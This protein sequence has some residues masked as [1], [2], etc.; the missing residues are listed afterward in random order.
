MR[1]VVATRFDDADP[2]RAAAVVEWPEPINDDYWV[3]IDVKAASLN[4]HDLWTLRGVGVDASQ[5]PVPLG[6]DVAGI[7]PDGN[8]VVVY[9]VV[10][11]ASRGGGNEMHD[12]KR[13]MLPDLGHGTFADRV[14]VPRNCLVAKPDSLSFEEA[15]CLPTSW[16]TAYRMLFT[17]AKVKSG[18]L[19]LIQG[20]GGGVSTALTVL[21]ASQGVRV[22]VASRSEEKREKALRA[23]AE[24]VFE[25]GARLPERVDA[26]MD[27]V[28][29]ATWGSTLRSLRLGGT[30][31]V[32]GTTGGAN[33]PAGLDR[34]FFQDLSVLGSAMGTMAEFSSLVSLCEENGLKPII[35]RTFPLDDAVGA[36]AQMQDGDVF[37][38]L[39]LRP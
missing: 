3:T 18:D 21:A 31:V 29:E 37:G 30:V 4:H 13:A 7:D 23:G 20:A 24:A 2:A 16:L 10:A 17:K 36:L 35:E 5:L 26:V 38:K 12:P 11:D 14:S 8:P 32:A 22:W 33:P 25:T 19:I 15:A 27:T 39:V 6:C 1:C 34:I 9:A 28:G